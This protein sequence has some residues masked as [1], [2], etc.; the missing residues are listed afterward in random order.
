MRSRSIGLNLRIDGN[1]L[2][3]YISN[4]SM[5]VVSSVLNVLGSAIRKSNRLGSNNS[6]IRISSLI[7]I[8]S[9]LRVVVRYSIGVEV[10]LRG[11]LLLVVGSRGLIRGRGMIGSGGS[12]MD[13]WSWGVGS[14]MVDNSSSMIGSGM[15]DSGG[16]VDL[17]GCSII[18]SIM[19][20]INSLRSSMRLTDYLCYTTQ[21]EV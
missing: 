2:I 12:S 6:T 15:V 21:S 17:Q 8:E 10:G 20:S 19:I 9:S 14:N 3:R 13:N 11:L 16:M 18:L 5:V 1:S 7:S 4:I